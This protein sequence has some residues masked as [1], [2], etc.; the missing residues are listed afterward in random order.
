VVLLDDLD[1]RVLAALALTSMGTVKLARRVEVC[2][3]TIR[4]RVRLLV[5]R[6]LVFADP[7]KFFSITDAGLAA[8]GPEAPQRPEPWVKVEAVSAARA[9]DVAERQGRQSVDDRTSWARSQQGSR[10]RLKALS[11]ANGQQ[12]FIDALTEFDRL[13]A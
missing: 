1:R 7:R 4:R 12:P 5:E 8:L 13:R 6:G 2:P 10:A 3:M 9:K 11:T